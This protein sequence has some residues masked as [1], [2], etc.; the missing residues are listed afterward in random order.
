MDQS[1]AL[2]EKCLDLQLQLNQLAHAYHELLKLMRQTSIDSDLEGAKKNLQQLEI[3]LSIHQ[4][5]SQGK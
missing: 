3:D 2:E 4:E 1:F 5:A